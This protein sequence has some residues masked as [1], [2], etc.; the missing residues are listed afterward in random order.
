VF[1]ENG[2]RIRMR[3]NVDDEVLEV[4]EDTGQLHIEP[5][6]MDRDEQKGE[7]QYGRIQQVDFLVEIWTATFSLK[8][9]QI[10]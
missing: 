10:P 8:I 6:H 5:I 9:L 4:V 2:Q 7:P 3:E 1:D